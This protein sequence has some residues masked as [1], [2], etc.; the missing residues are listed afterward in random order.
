[1]KDVNKAIIDVKTPNNHYCSD[2]GQLL[3]YYLKDVR[4]YETLTIDQE[5]DLFVRIK[6]GDN[7]ARNELVRANQRFVLAVAKRF[8]TSDNIMDLV[9][10]GNIGMLQAIEKFDVN[11]KSQTGEPIRFLSFAVWFIRREIS[12]FLINNCSL[13][14]KTNNVKTITKV[15]K[16][17]NTFFLKNGRYPSIDELSEIMENK[18]GIKI[19]DKS[20]LYDIETKYLTNTCNEENKRDTF[21]NSS[22]FNEKSASKNEYVYQAEKDSEKYQVSALLDMLKPRERTII[23]K[24]YGI[25]TDREY[26]IEE[27]AEELGLTKE[28]IRQIKVSSVKKLKKLAK[29]IAI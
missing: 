14:R 23:E 8:S 10:V 28:R 26:T 9:Q 24:L 15:N 5:R 3:S 29:S 20:Y 27:V 22:L 11:K 21:E 12:F 17:K 7:N 25:N 18:Y 16:L 4:K 19:K 13:V 2:N 6:D 1:M